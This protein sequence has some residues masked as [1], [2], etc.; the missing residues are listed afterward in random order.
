MV[1][2]RFEEKKLRDFSGLPNDSLVKVPWLLGGE[3]REDGGDIVMEFNPDRPD[4]YSIQ[5]ITRAIRTFAGVEK[6]VPQVFRNEDLEVASYPPK[7]RPYFTVGIVRGCK[8]KNLITEIIDFQEKIDLTVGRH[9]RL[10][11]I[12]LHDLKKI[13]FPI[14]YKEVTR[15]QK[16]VPLKESEEVQI[17]TF[18]KQHPKALEYGH[19]AGEKIPAIID[20]EDRIISLPPI[21]N[22]SITTATEETEDILVDVEG[23][24]LNAVERTMIL[25]LT[26]LS[27]PDGSIST[28]KM[29]GIITPKLEYH[30]KRITPNAVKKL[31]GYELPEAEM[32][33]ALE[34]M[35]YGFRDGNTIIPLYR[36]D[37]IAD[38]DVLE[39]VF[40][41]LGYDKIER[42]KEGFV[43]YGRANSLRAL[44]S[45]LRHL[46]VGYNLNETLSSVLVNGRYNSIFG[47][48]DD[49]TDLLNPVSQEQDSIRTRMSPSLVQTFMN[50]FRNPYP[51]RIFEIGSVFVKGKEKDVVGIGIA[52]KGASFSEIK[53][54]FVSVL[55][56]LGIEKYEITRDE[57]AM[58]A[59]GRIAG[60][61][62][63]EKKIGF[64]GEVH[65]MLLK[66]IGIRMPVVMGELDIQEVLS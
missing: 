32:T 12:G 28:L 51:Q 25:L 8:V 10:S 60:I 33:S 42:R 21:L 1:L 18:M 66:D 24:N 63:N 13:K 50:N 34:R 5:G 16:F 38:V 56:D 9:R 65:P 3:A 53:G 54:I 26:S 57:E 39:D 49:R 23:T 2:V 64:F 7:Y 48:N 31:L 61:V 41:G 59:P 35:G 40:K 52:D 30:E 6:F 27:Y 37:I 14:T 20:S 47:F 44:E 43:S 46:L 45:K 19:L 15:D 62:I 58:Y 11:S 4:L 29:N 55:E 36:T 22:S 17:D